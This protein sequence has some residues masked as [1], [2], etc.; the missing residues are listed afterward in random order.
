MW[1]LSL[2]RLSPPK[3][4]RNVFFPW[5]NF[6]LHQSGSY[7]EPNRVA[8][9]V[10]VN[11]T[12]LDIREYLRKLYG[13]KVIKVNTYIKLPKNRMSS[14][15]NWFKTDAQYKKA[16]VTCEEIIPNEVK[17]MHSCRDLRLNPALT[18]GQLDPKIN[19]GNPARPGQS[20][21]ND[22][23]PRHKLAWREPI[24]LL[25][26]TRPEGLVSSYPKM[27]DAQDEMEVQIDKTLPHTHFSNKRE[28]PEGVPPQKFPRVNADLI[29]NSRKGLISNTGSMIG[30]KVSVLAKR[31]SANR[32]V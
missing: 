2:Q 30:G 3:I 15:R 26:R 32:V 19:R 29:I 14:Y 22:W 12:K 11:M 31:L 6:V 9:R 23:K 10:P 1:T 16:I 18:K 7:L 28:I 20:R 25:L 8:F 17:M 21:S 24:P 13:V 27:F 5:Q 4:P